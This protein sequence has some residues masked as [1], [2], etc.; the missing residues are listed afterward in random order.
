MW[1]RDPFGNTEEF[2]PPSWLK[3]ALL[4]ALWFASTI[5]VCAL[6]CEHCSAAEMSR[7]EFASLYA[8]AY[9]NVG[10]LPERPPQIRF[11]S[12][13]RMCEVA[14]KP[15]CRMTG[16]E[17]AGEIYVIDTLDPRDP[18]QRSI[19]LH[20]LVHYVQWSKL[21]EAADCEETLR[22]EQE[23]YS[24]QIKALQAIG[25]ETRAL[26]MAMRQIRCS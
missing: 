2:E 13:A 25:H 18:Y 24:I 19:V 8:V 5:A 22:R 1:D 7:E 6:W 26:F 20:E 16:L 11:V 3:T 15:D 21:G 9:G 12:R 14:E 23:A 4:L 10:H 17:R